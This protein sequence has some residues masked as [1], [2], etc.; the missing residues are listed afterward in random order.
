MKRTFVLNYINTY[1]KL[2]ISTKKKPMG[3][4]SIVAPLLCT[5]MKVRI[6]KSA[7]PFCF[8]GFGSLLMS[9]FSLFFLYNVVKEDR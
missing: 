4:L 7:E 1:N 5:P 8:S 6:N 2:D 3:G 9:S